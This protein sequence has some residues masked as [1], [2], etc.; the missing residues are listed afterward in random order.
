[1]AAN[2]QPGDEIICS[3]HTMLATASAIKIAEEYQFC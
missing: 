2:L 1:M 3:A